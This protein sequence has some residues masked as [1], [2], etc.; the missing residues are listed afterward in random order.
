[1]R[2]R[3]KYACIE[4]NTYREK[5]TEKETDTDTQTQTHTDTHRHTQTHTHTHTHTHTP[6]A[7][8]FCGGAGCG[9]EA[10]RDF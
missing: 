1:V 9:T 4:R 5:H 8:V 6:A 3:K 10:S 7:W 2:V